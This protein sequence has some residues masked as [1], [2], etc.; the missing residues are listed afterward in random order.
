MKTSD[1][2]ASTLYVHRVS[3]P[4]ERTKFHP[5]LLIEVPR[6][7]KVSG[8]YDELVPAP[9]AKRAARVQ[10]VGLLV[11]QSVTWMYE[12]GSNDPQNVSRWGHMLQRGAAMRQLEPIDVTRNTRVL[13][14]DVPREAKTCGW[15]L[16]APG[17]LF[18]W[19]HI[20]GE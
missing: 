14:L 7:W 12:D 10:G 19:T 18:R 5:A 8:M 20:F 2:R 3:S 4:G 17:E 11:L 16:A 6:L 1:L 15:E 9:D 13:P